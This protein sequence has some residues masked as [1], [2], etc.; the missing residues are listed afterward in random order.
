MNKKLLAAVICLSMAVLLAAFGLYASH[1]A[2]TIRDRQDAEHSA[3]SSLAAQVSRERTAAAPK[4]GYVPAAPGTAEAPVPEMPAEP[5]ML[6]WY[7]PLYAQNPDLFGWLRIPGTVIDYPVMFT[8]EEPE[9]YLRRDFE[10]RE[11]LSGTLFMD[12]ACPPEGDFCL[13]YGHNMKNG[14]MFGSLIRYADAAFYEAHPTIL[15]DT[16]YETREYTVFAA[17]YS[18]VLPEDGSNA[19]R[20]Y[21]Y[22]DL[23]DPEVF[24]DY[25]E[26]V[27]RVSLID[28][29]LRPVWGDALITLST[30]SYH[31]G[32]GRFVVVAVQSGSEQAGTQREKG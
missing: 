17:F 12:G 2:R 4:P 25:V 7:A 24:A 21:N 30:C 20:Y 8:P 28:T 27:R 14:A 6:S 9:Y 22:T 5:E 23:S 18:Q 31:A 29:E 26:Q 11:S 3:F 1:R 10:G 19:F 16:L 13:I 32:D 15:F